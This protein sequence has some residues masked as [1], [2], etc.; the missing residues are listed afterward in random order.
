MTNKAQEQKFQAQDDAYTMA[1]YQEIMADKA[2]ASRAIK[3]AK[4][5]ASNMRKQADAMTK[6]ANTKSAAVRRTSKKK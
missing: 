3:V 1:R 6:V 5:Q 2:R 4:Q